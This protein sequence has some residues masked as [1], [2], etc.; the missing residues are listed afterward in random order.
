MGQVLADKDGEAHSKVTGK[1][2][3]KLGLGNVA[4]L[5][6]KITLLMDY[7]QAWLGT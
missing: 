4:S 2:R 3:A 7:A 1:R 6:L 5:S